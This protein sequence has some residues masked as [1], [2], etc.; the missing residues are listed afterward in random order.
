MSYVKIW[1]HA[2]WSTKNRDR[3]LTED[4]REKLFMHI[5]QNAKEKQIYIDQINGDMDHVHCLLALNADMT[6]AKVMQMIK[7]E[8]AYWANKNNL[9]KGTFEWANEYYAASVS[10]LMINKVRGYIMGQEEHHKKVTF[11]SE[12]DQFVEKLGLNIHG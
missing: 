4:V 2:V 9:L 6:I 10:E 3:I 7:G 1:I 5:R 8:S 11:K 12:Y